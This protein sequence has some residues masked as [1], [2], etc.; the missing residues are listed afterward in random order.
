V[1]PLPWY[2]ASTGNHQGLIISEA[3]GDNVAVTY[4]KEDAEPIAC[5]VNLHR[6]LVEMLDDV[7]ASLESVM[8]YYGDD[9][10]QEDRR[11]RAKHI[12]AAQALVS[13]ARNVETKGTKKQ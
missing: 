4:T 8:A 3:T 5:A 13:R 1:T 9:M 12:L 6:D 2:V 7:T 10:P 11:T